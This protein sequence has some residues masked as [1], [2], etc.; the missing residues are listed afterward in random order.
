MPVSPTF[1]WQ[2]F[3]FGGVADFAGARLG[4]LFLAQ[5]IAA[6]IVGASVVWVLGHDYSPVITQAIQ[7]LPEEASFTGSE[8]QGISDRVIS[9]SKFLSIAIETQSDEAIDQSADVQIEFRKSL[10]RVCS[11]FRSAIGCV[12]FN[13]PK[14]R[15]L[16]LSRSKVEPWWGAWQPVILTGA[17]IITMA[18]LLLTW[19][20]L[21]VLYSPVARLLAWFLDRNLGWGG[22]WKLSA[23][24]LLPGAMVMIPGILFYGLRVVDSIGLIFFFAA[25]W[26]VG[27]IYLMGAPF[28]V[29]RFESDKP[30]S[31]PFT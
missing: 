18:M 1:A 14:D 20:I 31:N 8:I 19:A 23:A 11:L 22:A 9:E 16:N 5:I 26:I 3:T 2:P 10:Y 28:F 27:W 30:K 25:H 6:A 7:K 21:A 15:S 29:P 17:G 12:E 4:R 13:Y 24:A